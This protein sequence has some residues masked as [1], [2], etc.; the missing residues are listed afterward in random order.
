MFSNLGIEQFIIAGVAAVISWALITS[1]KSIGLYLK[2]RMTSEEYYTAQT[3]V[4]ALVMRAETKYRSSEGQ[5]KLKYVI[6][7]AEKNL[8]G[9]GL[10]IDLDVLIGLIETSVK[11]ELGLDSRPQHMGFPVPLEKMSEEDKEERSNI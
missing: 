5:A 4:R 11:D 9:I 7:V 6:E 1:V 3:I 10:T 8:S 2:A